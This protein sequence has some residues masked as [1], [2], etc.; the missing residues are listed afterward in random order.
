MGQNPIGCHH[1]PVAVAAANRI[2]PHSGPILSEGC[3]EG[4]PAVY[5]PIQCTPLLVKKAGVPP[6]VTLRFTTCKQ[7]HVQARGPPWF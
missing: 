7:A 6:D 2:S 5:M 1:C 3:L 4:G